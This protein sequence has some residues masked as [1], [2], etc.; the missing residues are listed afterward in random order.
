MRAEP[1]IVFVRKHDVT[2]ERLDASRQM[3]GV[4]I[5]LSARS[6]GKRRRE[7]VS[8]IKRISSLGYVVTFHIKFLRSYN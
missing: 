1:G 7:R 5:W 2:N 4:N 3:R 8:A 6:R